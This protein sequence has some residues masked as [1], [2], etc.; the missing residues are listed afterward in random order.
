MS[1]PKVQYC[2]DGASTHIISSNPPSTLWTAQE[3]AQIQI[4]L[5]RQL[6]PEYLT[7]RPGPGGGPKVT[8]IEGHKVVSLANEVFGFNGWFTS[9]QNITVDFLDY[10]S[11]TGRCSVGV[12]CVIRVT[13][14][15]GAYHE[16][17]G[18]G[19]CENA[20]SRTQA[21]E[22]AKKEASTDSLKRTLK[23]FG[24]VLGNCLYDKNYLRD[25]GNVKAPTNKFN[26]DSLHRRD[27]THGPKQETT[28]AQKADTPQ[29]SMEDTTHDYDG[30]DDE[31]LY[32]SFDL[33][34]IDMSASDNKVDQT[35][36][37]VARREEQA[38]KQT[39][40]SRPVYRKGTENMPPTGMSNAAMRASTPT[41]MLP[42]GG[43][44]GMPLSARSP[45]N[46]PPQL[47]KR[48]ANEQVGNFVKTVR[49]DPAAIFSDIM[50]VPL[51]TSEVRF[52]SAKDVKGEPSVE[53]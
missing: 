24:N 8:Y 27:S 3:I 45:M 52:V 44:V 23:S 19:S 17:I 18:Y 4:K 32:D 10:N 46:V 22:K 28:Q 30:F 25:V 29:P 47:G 33:T 49:P 1:G 41:R 53:T 31:S 12:S 5:E 7:S 14:K 50:D 15:D 51:D 9:I 6:G 39:S 26:P 20:R 40:A 42:P 43:R 35:P 48:K 34:S 21:L 36:P 16:D 11:D 2:A 13:L 37:P 38:P